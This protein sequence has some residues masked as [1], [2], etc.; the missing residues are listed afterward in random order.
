MQLTSGV[1]RI[2][3]IDQCEITSK[4][5]RF[6]GCN[7]VKG[8]H[9]DT[10]DEPIV[11]LYTD[12]GVVGWGRSNETE[13]MAKLAVGKRVDEVFSLSQ[14][15]G[16]G[17]DL[18]DTALWDLVGRL[19]ENPVHALLGSHG[20][21]LAP[22]YD[23]SIYMEDIDP[24]TGA[25]RGLG[26]V[27]EAVQ[28]GLEFGYQAFKMK[29]GRGNK[30][31]ERKAGFTRDVE[32]IRRVRELIGPDHRLLMDGNNAYTQ[33]EARELVTQVRDCDVFWFEE[34]FQE[35]IDASL[36]FKR[37]LHESDHPVLLADGESARPW[38]EPIRAVLR[39]QALDVVQFDLRPVPIGQWLGVLPLIEELGI[40]AAP[41]NWHSMLLNYYIPHFGRG[42]RIFCMGETDTAATPDVDTSNYRLVD[43][44]LEIPDAPG[45]GLALDQSAIDRRVK[46]DGWSVSA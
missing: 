41:H 18:L 43:G 1:T 17:Y 24:E 7:S 42:M 29:I 13:E 32:A 35:E 19:E 2:T 37:F 38:Q 15:A 16:F 4:R 3:R 44:K 8:A 27:D 5:P 31:M 28:A 39:A 26:L 34:P 33:E 40:V 25:D 21:K 6:I 36:S 10:I 23:G 30:W 45:F 12:A 9:G 46:S 14:G 20:E 11:R 22:I